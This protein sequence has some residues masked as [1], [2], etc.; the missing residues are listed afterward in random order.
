MPKAGPAAAS[1]PLPPTQ[2]AG[3]EA[4]SAV[5]RWGENFVYNYLR[6]VAAGTSGAGKPLSWLPLGARVRW[7]NEHDEAFEV[8][9]GPPIAGPATY[10]ML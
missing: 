8:R 9:V 6:E 7:M 4:R 2:A 1:R 10:P 3:D 5:G